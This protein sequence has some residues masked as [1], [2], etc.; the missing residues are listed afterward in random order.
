MAKKKSSSG[1]SG[2]RSKID[3]F[4]AEVTEAFSDLLYRPVEL[5]D[6]MR[7]IGPPPNAGDGLLALP[8]LVHRGPGGCDTDGCEGFC[9]RP[10]PTRVLAR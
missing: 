2:R 4:A 8:T 6:S 10:R 9:I 3:P 5:L 1:F 7:P